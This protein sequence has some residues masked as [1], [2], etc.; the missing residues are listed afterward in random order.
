MLTF[1]QLELVNNNPVDLA[2]GNPPIVLG[3]IW[4]I[5]L[6]FEVTEKKMHQW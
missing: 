3:L 5:I 6:H 1:F 4:Q 2:N